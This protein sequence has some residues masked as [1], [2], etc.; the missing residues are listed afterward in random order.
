M[1][2]AHTWNV[3]VPLSL[4]ICEMEEVCS[5]NNSL[6]SETWHLECLHIPF[7]STSPGPSYV[8]NPECLFVYPLPL[9]P[10]SF[11]DSLPCETAISVSAPPTSCLHLKASSLHLIILPLNL[12]CKPQE[13]R[14][15]P[16]IKS[17]TVWTSQI[18][19]KSLLTDPVV[20]NFNVE[21]CIFY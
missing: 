11:K 10:A 4:S 15:Q 8:L 17:L 14:D 13:G 12:W 20:G 2:H 9:K 3:R 7:Y 5:L 21:K 18:L 16:D 1:S 19:D 6:F